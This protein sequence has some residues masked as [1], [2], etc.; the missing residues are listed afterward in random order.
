VARPSMLGP[1]ASKTLTNRNR[2]SDLERFEEKQAF[3]SQFSVHVMH[4]NLPLYQ[5]SYREE[6]MW[7]QGRHYMMLPM[8]WRWGTLLCMWWPVGRGEL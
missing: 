3:P 6:V 5:L 2:T 7:I 8:W 4:Y 1:L